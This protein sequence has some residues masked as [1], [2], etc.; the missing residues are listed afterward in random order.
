MALGLATAT[1]TMSIVDVTIL[2]PL[3][4]AASAEIV[5][6]SQTDKSSG[7]PY[8]YSHRFFYDALNQFSGVQSLGALSFSDFILQNDDESIVVSGLACS[9]SLFDVLGIKPLHGRLFDRTEE[10]PDAD[11]S[12]AIIS[13]E[14][15]RERYGSDPNILGKTIRLNELPFTVVGIMKAGLRLPP[16]PAAPG[17]WIPLGSDPMIAQVQKMFPSNWDRAAYITPLWAR[18]NPGLNLK[19]VEEQVKAVSL[20]LLAQDDSFFSPDRNLRLIP[21][22]EQIKSAYRTEAYVLILAALLTLIVSCFNVSSLILAWSLSRHAEFSLRL[23]LGESQLRIVTRMLLEGLLISVSGALAGI[24]IIKFMLQAIE[25]AIPAG[26]LPYREIVLGISPLAIILVVAVACGIAV[27]IWPAFRLVRLSR[28][29][30]TDGLH[31]SSTQG[32]S[33]RL[34]RQI[35]MVAQI[36]CAALAILLF[37]SLFHSYQLISATQLGFDADPVL[38]ANLKLPQN[39]ASG[40]RWKQ[41]GALLTNNLTSQQGVLSTAMAISP[42]IT[43]SL[44]TS[45]KISSNRAQKSDGVADYRGVGPNYFSLLGIPIRKGRQFSDSDTSKSKS[46]CILNETLARTHFA[47]EQ[48]I[49]AQIA[50]IGMEPCEVVGVVGDV[51]SHN[52]KDRPAPAIYV[53]FNQVPNDAIQ[54]SLSVLVRPGGSTSLGDL[55]YQKTRLAQTIRQSAPTLPT[56]VHR[57]AEI[58]AERSSPERFRAILMAIVSLIAVVLAACGVYGIAANYVL[59]R[60]RDITIRLALGTTTGRVIASILKDALVLAAV[61]LALG[62]SS[63]YPTLKTLSGVLIGITEPEM[64]V[65]TASSFIM[66]SIVLISAYIPTRRILRLNIADVLKE[67]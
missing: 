61:G 11:G 67:V 36:A 20:P 56:S 44:R 26:L 63:A 14:L 33:I 8:A 42:P 1:V 5:E 54:G 3:P 24:M 2:H 43:R 31:R 27:S 65:I 13:E 52:L 18:L 60:R 39:A 34:S 35:L 21:V 28:G 17:V 37:L 50:P 29:N 10:A 49:G 30:L 38:V 46:V 19:A 41:L 6:I 58:V 7:R 59:Q 4:Y 22:E 47:Q 40:E 16:L 45:Y 25:S 12:I 15:W 66:L 51:A 62:I 48:E 9:A 32:R 23:M 55:D 53:P 64:S 57:L